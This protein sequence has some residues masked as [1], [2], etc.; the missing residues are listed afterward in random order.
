MIWQLRFMSS[1]SCLFIGVVM[2]AVGLRERAS[3]YNSDHKCDLW[4]HLA[5]IAIW[6]RHPDALI[7]RISWKE[8]ADIDRSSHSQYWP[9]ALFT[10][11]FSS[12]SK[13]YNAPV[14]QLD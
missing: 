13:S 12:S 5:D 2:D 14:A 7:H 3:D 4:K 6:Q 8:L 10:L 11:P 9:E 1:D